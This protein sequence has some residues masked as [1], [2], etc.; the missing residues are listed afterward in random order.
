MTYAIEV[1]QC[2]GVCL[3]PRA[4]SFRATHTTTRERC[5]GG[6]NL[7]PSLWS[8]NVRDSERRHSRPALA[9]EAQS[10]LYVCRAHTHVLG[11]AN[12]AQS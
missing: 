2:R 9:T 3:S 1:G 10:V 8:I 12:S 5:H 6:R 4:W 7:S 11:A